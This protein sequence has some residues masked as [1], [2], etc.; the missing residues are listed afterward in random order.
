MTK[1]LE[2]NQALAY[3]NVVE[4]TFIPIVFLPL[5]I[6]QTTYVSATVIEYTD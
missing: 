1:E 4:S 5:V 3:M 2:P 6:T